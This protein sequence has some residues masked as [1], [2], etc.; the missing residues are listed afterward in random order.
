MERHDGT[1]DNLS[2]EKIASLLFRAVDFWDSAIKQSL[3]SSDRNERSIARSAF[4]V[5]DY[6]RMLPASLHPLLQTVVADRIAWASK[7]NSAIT[8][9][10]KPVPFLGVLEKGALD[11]AMKAFSMRE[12]WESTISNFLRIWYQ[13]SPPV[14]QS[15]PSGEAYTRNIEGE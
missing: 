9:G 14:Q 2:S 5:N 4:R 6:K 10:P 3:K 7:P 12:D 8:E 15:G 11:K 13:Y 1:L